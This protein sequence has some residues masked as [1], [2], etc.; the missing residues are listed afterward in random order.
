MDAAFREEALEFHKRARGKVQIYPT[1]DIK[2]EQQLALMYVP[3]SIAACEEIMK[4]P[5]AAYKYTGKAN[6]IAEVSNG[7]ALLGLGSKGPD[8]SIPILEGKCLLFKLFGDISAIPMPI[9]APDHRDVISF[10]RMIAPAFGGINI[11]DIKSP[12]VFYIL[13]ELS[14]TMAT[15][16][17][18]DDLQGSAMIVLAAVRNSLRL[19]SITLAEAKIVIVGAGAAGMASAELLLTA[20]AKD[21]IV[22]DESGILCDK[23]PHMD[24]LQADLAA[25]TDP[26]GVTGGIDE[27]IA[28]ADIV[29]GLSKAGAI[30]PEH[31]KK[32]NRKPVVLALAL[33]EPEIT[34]AEATEA[35]AFI[36]ASGLLED[37]N[38]MLNIH[39]FPGLIRGT[40]AVCATRITDEMLIAGA[41][42][43]ANMIDR[44]HLTPDHICPRFFGSETTPRVAEAVGQAAIASKAAQIEVPSGFIYEDTWYRLFGET[45]PKV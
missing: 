36:Y 43:L 19:L 42:A 2:N 37:S 4:D 18:C 32:M 14:G 44:R 20:G 5:S 40:L 38:T 22:L 34:C 3:G 30:K 8:A 27:A 23:A 31:I 21:L 24:P 41:D 13:R 28:G 16:V 11:E 35:G 25:R 17:F 12:D 9:D 29:I 1:V 7:S 10:C 33:P 26:R 39:A 15:P 6:R 45:L